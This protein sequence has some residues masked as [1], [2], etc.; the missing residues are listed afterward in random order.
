MPTPE[1]PRDFCSEV[2]MTP[3]QCNEVVED[4]LVHL[5]PVLKCALVTFQRVE[6]ALANGAFNWRKVFAKAKKKAL[7]ES[8]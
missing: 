5:E 7:D 3:A 4:K 6:Q 8:E 1:K 2:E